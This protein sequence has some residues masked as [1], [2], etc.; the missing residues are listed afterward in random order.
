MFSRLCT[1]L[2]NTS[3]SPRG[4]QLV[5]KRDTG[6]LK[7][8]LYIEMSYIVEAFAHANIEANQDIKAIQERNIQTV[9][10]KMKDFSRREV[11]GAIAAR[12]AQ[13]KM[14][15]PPDTKF[16]QLINS[17]SIKNCKVTAQDISNSR[18]IFGPDL[19]GL[20]WRTNRKKPTRV[21]P[22][23]MGIPRAIYERYKDLVLTADVMFVNGIAFLV[24]LS[25]GIR[26]Y[27]TEHL[28][29]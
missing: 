11:K 12:K 1:S 29:N 20:Q 9:R 13:I 23:Y 18:V 27:T 10:M 15:H 21:V 7:N 24:T 16:K 26:L 6:N 5:F 14:G 2:L 25:R 19:P 4:K 22:V 17:D 8:M 3:Y 28:P